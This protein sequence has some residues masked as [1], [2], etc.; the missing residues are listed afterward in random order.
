MKKFTTPQMP[1][2]LLPHVYI[3]KKLPLIK[4]AFLFK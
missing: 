4:V 1:S 3:K 2:K